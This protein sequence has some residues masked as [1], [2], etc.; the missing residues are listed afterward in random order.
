VGAATLQ[1]D[2]EALKELLESDGEDIPEDV[3]VIR[4]DDA[5]RTDVV[6]QLRFTPRVYR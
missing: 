6:D 5:G 1:L 3:F 2:E 4:A